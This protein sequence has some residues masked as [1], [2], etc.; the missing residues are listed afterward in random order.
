MIAVGLADYPF[1]LLLRAMG[2]YN[3]GGWCSR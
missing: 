2:V 3:I 1:I